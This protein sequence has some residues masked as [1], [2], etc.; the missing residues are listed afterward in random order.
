[1]GGRTQRPGSR[2]KSFNIA[3]TSVWM[4][5]KETLTEDTEFLTMTHLSCGPEVHGAD[6]AQ[7]G[8]S[9]NLSG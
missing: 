6:Q 8:A 1:M 2:R 7:D 3:D 4:K 9:A 5:E